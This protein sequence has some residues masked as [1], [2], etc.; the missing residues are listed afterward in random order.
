MCRFPFPRRWRYVR[1][2][3]RDEILLTAYY[4]IEKSKFSQETRSYLVHVQFQFASLRY[5][6]VQVSPSQ[7]SLLNYPNKKKFHHNVSISVVFQTT[8]SGS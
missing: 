3:F 5:C 4:E 2:T 7:F 8:H 1:S 6:Y